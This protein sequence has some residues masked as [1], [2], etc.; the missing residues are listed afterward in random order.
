V[1]VLEEDMPVRIGEAAPLESLLGSE[2]LGRLGA[3][4]AVDEDGVLR[5]V[6]TLAQVQ[7]ALRPPRPTRPAT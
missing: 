3:M 2:G 4:V 1:D 5:G 7:G 6:V